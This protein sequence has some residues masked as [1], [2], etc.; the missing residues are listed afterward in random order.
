MAFRIESVDRPENYVDFEVEQADGK[1]VEFSIPKP[2]CLPPSMVKKLNDFIASQDQSVSVVDVNRETLKIMV[3]A[4]KKL[5]DQLAQ[6]QMQAIFDH[7][8]AE[9]EASL[10][11]SEASTSS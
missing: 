9:A 3:P 1:L 6:R 2:D 5:F 10:G 4:H 7:W 11:E 8:N